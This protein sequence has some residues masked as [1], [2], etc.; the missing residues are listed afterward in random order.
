MPGDLYDSGAVAMNRA[1]ILRAR[2]QAVLLLPAT[3][4]AR[5]LK[6]DFADSALLYLEAG[7]AWAGPLFQPS[8]NFNY[9][10]APTVQ[11]PRSRPR[12]SGS[13]TTRTC[14]PSA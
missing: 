3:V 5:Y 10:Q 14:G 12:R 6:I 1:V 7:L 4:T 9:G 8:R 11:D 13:R 2:S